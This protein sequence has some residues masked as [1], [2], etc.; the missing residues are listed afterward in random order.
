MK[1]S[2]ELAQEFLFD[3]NETIVELSHVEIAPLALEITLIT[4]GLADA[5]TLRSKINQRVEIYQ[6]TST[7]LRATI[8]RI[9]ADSIR[10]YLA[11]NQGEYFQAVLL[12]A[13]RDEMA[14]TNHIHLEGFSGEREVDLTFLFE[15]YQPPMSAKEAAKRMK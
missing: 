8:E 3:E 4:C 15:R 14:E 5:L 12:R 6:K 9:S 10:V 7:N 2:L 13:Y 1:R 11:K